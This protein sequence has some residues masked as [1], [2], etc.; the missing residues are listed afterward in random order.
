MLALS[1]TLGWDNCSFTSLR[2][3]SL[4]L[5][6]HTFVLSS[7][8]YSVTSLQVF[9]LWS[10]KL[11]ISYTTDVVHRLLSSLSLRTDTFAMDQGVNHR[12]EH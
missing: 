1:V 9:S 7:R 6:I 8:I 5:L 4:G 11:D 12:V 10:S 2:L 3:G